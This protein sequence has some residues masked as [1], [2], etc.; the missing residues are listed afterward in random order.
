MDRLTPEEARERYEAEWPAINAEKLKAIAANDKKAAK[1]AR[2]KLSRLSQKYAARFEE[3]DQPDSY[4]PAVCAHCTF[5]KKNFAY[6]HI[7][8]CNLL[9]PPWLAEQ[10]LQEAAKLVR[11]DAT[12]DFYKSKE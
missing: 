9:L 11:A 10:Y 3:R 8:S 1:L 4:K 6:P 5:F 7:G 12:C 2:Q